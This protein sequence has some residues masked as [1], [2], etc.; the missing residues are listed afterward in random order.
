MPSTWI[1]VIVVVVVSGLREM[2]SGA[3]INGGGNKELRIVT[4]VGKLAS[5][6]GGILETLNMPVSGEAPMKK[7]IEDVGKGKER[8]EINLHADSLGNAIDKSRDKGK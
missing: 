2:R 5:S 7:N 1:T 4:H 6:G 3:S 8:L